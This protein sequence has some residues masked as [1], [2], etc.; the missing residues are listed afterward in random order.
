VNLP[1]YLFW[2]QGHFHCKN[3]PL[4]FAATVVPTETKP[5]IRNY[6]NVK[7]VKENNIA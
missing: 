3:D 2:N 5:T 1:Q 7:N 4:I 6:M